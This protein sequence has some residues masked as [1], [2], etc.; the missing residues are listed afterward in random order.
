MNRAGATASPLRSRAGAGAVCDRPAGTLSRRRFLTRS[1]ALA[2][3]PLAA[4][5]GAAAAEPDVVVIGAG[6]AG[7]AATRILRER[8]VPVVTVEAS[9]RIGGRAHTD[10]RLFGVPFDLGAHWLHNAADNPFV[11]YA[12]EQGFHAYPAPVSETLY[13]GDRKANPAEYAAYRAAH[14]GAIRAMSAAGRRGEDRSPAAVVPDGGEWHDLVHFVIGPWEMGKDF[15]DFSCVDWWNSEDGTDWYC[16]EGYGALLAHGGRDL[17]VLLA[18][19]AER[20]RWGGKGVSVD[21]ERGTLRARH[22]I[23]TVSTG[24]LAHGGLR[25][26]PELPAAKEESFHGIS[27]GLYDHI[28]LLFDEN[29]LGTGADEYL[30]YNADSHGAPSPALMGL[31]T[32]VSGTRLTLADVGGDFAAE[33]EEAGP[34]AALDFARSEL[35]RI[36]GARVRRHLVKAHFTRWGRNPLTRG[37]YASARPGAYPLRAV[38]REPVAERV[39][40]AGEACSEGEWATVGGAHKSGRLTGERVAAALAATP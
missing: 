33:L 38:L 23:V 37:S 5:A 14:A 19:R 2:A 21:T 15:D 6:A 29:V 9:G 28:A 36:F 16:K 26:S 3:L 8:G 11:R 13:R 25:F 35:E 17:E 18:T 40:F 20:I 12:R 24:V 31:L 1:A 22:C 32:N 4:R 30:L 27:M 7:L 39:W 10:T 34:D